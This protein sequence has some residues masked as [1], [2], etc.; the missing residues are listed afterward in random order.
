[1]NA[2]ASVDTALPPRQLLD[3][4]LSIE[5]RLG[6][7]RDGPR[8]GPRT[9]DLDLLLYGDEVVDEPGLRVPYA[10][11]VPARYRSGPQPAVSTQVV[12][13]ED[14]GATVLHYARV[15]SCKA[16]G[17]CRRVDGRSISPLVG[18][19]GTWPT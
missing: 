16:A 2:A 18:G 9:I 19:G 10:V 1:M 6:R 13:N 3:A 14:A 8:Y 11:R 7:R 17:R 12:S 4:L 15:P 5:R